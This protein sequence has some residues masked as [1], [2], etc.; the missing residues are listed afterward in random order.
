MTVKSIKGM[1]GMTV[2]SIKGMKGMTVKS[3]KGMKVSESERLQIKNNK[4]KQNK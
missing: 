3:N 4:K 2:K 1:K